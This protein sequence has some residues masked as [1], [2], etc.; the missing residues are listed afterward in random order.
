MEA[1]HQKLVGVGDPSS[2]GAC[3]HKSVRPVQACVIT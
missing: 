2:C 3:K 1:E